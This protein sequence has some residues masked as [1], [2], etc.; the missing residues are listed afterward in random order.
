MTSDPWLP[1]DFEHPTRVDLPTGHHLRPIE[2]RDVDIDYPAVMGSRERL[3][4]IFGPPWGWPPATMTFEQDR[5]DLERHE[6]EQ[7]AHQSFNYCV[8]NAD[9]SAL[10]GCVY[11]DPAEKAGADADISWWVVDAEVGGALDSTLADFVPAWIAAV[12]PFASPRFIGRDLTWTDW[13][14][15]PDAVEEK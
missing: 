13:L 7:H 10:L 14:A 15:L 4:E 8:L 9:G 3:F 12:W 5:A 1:G 2:G 11:I 6:R